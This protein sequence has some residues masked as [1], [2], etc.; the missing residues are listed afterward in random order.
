MLHEQY[1]TNLTKNICISAVYAE[2]QM[3][4][5]MEQVTPGLCVRV[6]TGTTEQNSRYTML[7]PKGCSSAP[8]IDQQLEANIYSVLWKWRIIDH[9]SGCKIVRFRT[10]TLNTATTYYRE[11]ISFK[12]IPTNST[13]CIILPSYLLP[14][15]PTSRRYAH[16]C[17]YVMY[18]CMYKGG[19]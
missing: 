15:L 8:R 10:L 16:V 13:T 6:A 4:R 2:M 3:S 17:M 11:F 9:L 7:M 12:S 19:P 14:D 1:L 5:G 18:V